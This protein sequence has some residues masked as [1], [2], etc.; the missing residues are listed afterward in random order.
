MSPRAALDFGFVAVITIVTLFGAL[1]PRWCFGNGDRLSPTGS[2]LFHLGNMLAAG[3][4]LGTAFCD[5]LP[6]AVELLP[7]EDYPM[8]LCLS[9]VGYILTLL[10]E[11]VIT[12]L[13]DGRGQGKTI[14][15]SLASIEKGLEGLKNNDEPLLG[16]LEAGQ[17][18]EIEEEHHCTPEPPKVTF[19]AAVILSVALSYHSVMAGA[20]IGAQKN[21]VVAKEVMLAVLGHKGLEAY[22]LGTSL[23]ESRT[24]G[25]KF[26]VIVMTYCFT[27][28]CGVLAGFF[29]ADLSEAPV[30]GVLSALSAGTFFFVSF[31]EIIPTEM[32]EPCHRLKKLFSLV[33]GFGSMA[34]LP[35]FVRG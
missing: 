32:L 2:M 14:N 6:E 16:Q 28:P 23:V 34:V 3:A 35:I 15:S 17:G 12:S 26:W 18:K 8:A 20:A 29:M 4:I 19:V 22:A 31:N 27:L 10:M 11:V 7:F 21:L 13:S 1:L 25:A 9:G 5:L 33:V 24:S 30:A